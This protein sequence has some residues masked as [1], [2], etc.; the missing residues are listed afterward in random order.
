MTQNDFLRNSGIFD[1]LCD[2][3]A[4]LIGLESEFASPIHT[5]GEVAKEPNVNTFLRAP[6][7]ERRIDSV[8]LLSVRLRLAPL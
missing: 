8:P 5:A 3:Y 4:S 2:I 7:V 6:C 1:F